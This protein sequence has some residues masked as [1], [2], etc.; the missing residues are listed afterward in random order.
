MVA[1]TDREPL[2]TSQKALLLSAPFGDYSVETIAVPAP[3]PEEVLVKVMVAALNPADWSFQTID[4]YTDSYPITTGFDG[5]GIVVAVGSGVTDITEGDR[6]IFQ[7]SFDENTKKLH[8]TFRQYHVMP[9]HT[10]AKIPPSISFE[11]G[12]TLFSASVVIAIAL[13]SHKP[14]TDSFRLTPPWESEGRGKYAGKPI[15]IP[16]GS[17]Q[18]GL[19]A[20]QF[21][22]LSGFAPIITTTSPHNADLA[23]SYGATHVLD[24]TLPAD[25]VIEEVQAI[26]GGPVDL[27]Y[28]A[29]SEPDTLALSVAVLCPRGRL[30]FVRPDMHERVGGLVV[31][32]ELQALY[33]Q[34][35]QCLEQ[36]RGALS[37]FYEKL[38]ALLEEG[39][40]RPTLY[41]VLPG[42]L[43]AVPAGVA[44]HRDK[45]V[46]GVKLVV[47]PHDTE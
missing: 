14:G 6:V 39:L 31:E 45:Q 21:A 44:R 10:L 20:L 17:S 16:G 4:H 11:Q 34:G 38:P 9:V 25:R 22:K 36:T 3:G 40:I 46:S 28:D 2:P 1:P 12:A 43:H 41:E 35:A 30:V 29:I 18:V 27:V 42:G 47:H 19:F 24:R 37:G 15:F 32:K 26:A 7:A 8:G 13:Y 33:A 5:A 23:R